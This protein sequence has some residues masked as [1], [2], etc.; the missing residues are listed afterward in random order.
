LTKNR[1]G[2]I[3]GDFFKASSAV[4]VMITIFCHFHQIS[5]NKLAF[6]LKTNVMIH[7]LHNSAVFLNQKTPIFSPIFWQKYFKN[8]NIGLW[9]PWLS[10]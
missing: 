4:G 3:L 1:L 10:S 9:S 6:F 7:F 8:H 2:Y 5:A